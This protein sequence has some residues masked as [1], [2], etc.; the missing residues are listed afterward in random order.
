M[1]GHVLF[2]QQHERHALAAQFLVN[3][4]EVGLSV[5]AGAIGSAAHQVALQRRL[6]QA[7]NR[8]PVQPCGSSQAGVLG[9][10]TFGDAQGGGD[11]FVRK[12]CLEFE[13]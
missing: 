4:T 13:T 3:T 12:P 8:W 5:V 10:D 11:A 7:F 6:A 9:H 2:P 1:L